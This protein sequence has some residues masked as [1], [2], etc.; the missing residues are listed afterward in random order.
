MAGIE[1]LVGGDPRPNQ[2][3]YN[4][5][6]AAKVHAVNGNEVSLTIAGFPSSQVYAV[7]PFSGGTPTEDMTVFLLHDS[8]G[9]PAIA[10]VPSG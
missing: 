1:E 4:A 7:V 2:T 10:V 3:P 9:H 6:V 8:N 5:I